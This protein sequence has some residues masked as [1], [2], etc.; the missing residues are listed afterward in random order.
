MLLIL[1]QANELGG[2]ERTLVHLLRYLKQES[3]DRVCVAAPT[4]LFRQLPESPDEF[5]PTDGKIEGFWFQDQAV[6]ARDMAATRRIVQRVR[7]RL[8][9]GIMH[10]AAALCAG[11]RQPGMRVVASLR[12]PA[13]EYIRRYVTEPKAARFQRWEIGRTAWHADRV[14]VPSR[15][16]AGELIRR[17]AAPPWKIRVIPN[18][19]DIKD[20]VRRAR[21]PLPLGM[22]LSGSTPVIVAMARLSI[23]KRLDW[24]LEAFRLVRERVE[25]HLL[26]IG[27]GPDQESLEARARDLGLGGDVRFAGHQSNP[28]PLLKSADVF[29][30]TCEFEGFG[31]SI[32]EAMALGVPVVA[33]DCPYG[34]REII[35]HKEN[36]LLVPPGD[37][38]GM[39]EALGELLRRDEYR[40][41]I[42]AAGQRDVEK[43]SLNNML[44]RH[45][46]LFASLLPTAF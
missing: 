32:I 41:H 2:A 29:V 24:L 12:G 37:I 28:F 17:F 26:V 21:E 22:G 33:T 43:F 31:Y 9:I 30:H 11:S 10:Y 44:S 4:R 15:G 39:A 36:G 6:L 18:G 19:I 7:P 35:R 13:Y 5:V 40:R 3:T 25:A 16:T 42:A 45:R 20:T 1:H 27:S 8:A 23:E 34:P 38:A 46:E 14:L